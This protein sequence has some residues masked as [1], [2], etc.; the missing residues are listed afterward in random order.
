MTGKQRAYLRGLANTIDAKYQIGKNGVD[1]NTIAMID[2][3]LEANELI[4]VKVLENSFLD[5]R[6]TC[7]EICD[8]TGAQSVQMIGRK[9]VF[10]REA[11]KDENRKIELP[12][13]KAKK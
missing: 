3:A 1:E 12:A 11:E 8:A 5:V 10:Y 7:G 4:K 13:K 9:I 6:E 2:E